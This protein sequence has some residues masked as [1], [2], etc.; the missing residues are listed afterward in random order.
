MRGIVADQFERAWIVA[1]EKLD[2][3]V[4]LDRIGEVGKLAVE[5]HRDRALG[6]RR[7]N[8]FGNIQA[9]NI[10]RVLPTRAVGKG[11]RDHHSLLLITRCLRCG[12]S[13]KSLSLVFY[14]CSQSRLFALFR[15]CGWPSIDPPTIAVADIGPRRPGTSRAGSFVYYP[16]GN[17]VEPRR[18]LFTAKRAASGYRLLTNKGLSE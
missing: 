12:V 5:R 1:G 18:G 8:A 15:L 7:R 10:W 13:G 11:Q 3:G 17:F 6:K 9:T 16:R 14:R 4:V 2:L